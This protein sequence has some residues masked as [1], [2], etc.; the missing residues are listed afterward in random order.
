VRDCG[1]AAKSKTN[2]IKIGNETTKE[3]M[4]IRKRAK[5]RRGLNTAIDDDDDCNNNNNN[6][7]DEMNKKKLETKPNIQNAINGKDQQFERKKRHQHRLQKE[8]HRQENNQENTREMQ[9]GYW[10]LSGH[11]LFP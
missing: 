6:N 5:I 8:Q 4:K 11:A 3:N 7:N 10:V 9:T 2:K 1:Q